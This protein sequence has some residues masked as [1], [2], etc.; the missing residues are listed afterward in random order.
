MRKYFLIFLT[1]SFSVVYSQTNSPSEIG[2]KIIDRVIG[3]TSFDLEVVQQQPVLDIQVLDFQKAGCTGGISYALCY[4]EAEKDTT[5]ELCISYSV[6]VK[7]FLNDKKIYEDKTGKKFHFKE[8]AYGIFEFN[9]TVSTV[10]KKGRN[11]ILVKS[12]VRNES[13]FI[14]L[15]ELTPAEGKACLSFTAEPTV[16]KLNGNPWLFIG[17]FKSKSLN[18]VFPPENKFELL[19][20]TGKNE[21]KWHTVADNLLLSA[22]ILPQAKF[23]KEAYSEWTYANGAMFFTILEF[24]KKISNQKYADFAK[25]FCNFTVTT[26]PLFKKQY[27]SDHAFRGFNHRIFRKQ[28][29][30]DAGAPVLPF[31]QLLL[32]GRGSEYKNIVDEMLGYIINEQTKLDDGTLCRIEPEAYTIWAD[33]LFMSVPLLLR[34]AEFTK[35]KKYYDFAANQVL[36]FNKYLFDPITGLY[37]HGYFIRTKKTSE[38]FWARANGWVAWANSEA[39]LHISKDHPAYEKIK[40]NF[41]RHINGLISFQDE[42]GMWHQ[43]LNDKTTFEETSSTAMFIV[44]LARGIKNGWIDKKYEPNLIR[45]WDALKKNI[46]GDGTVKNICRGTGIGNTIEFYAKRATFENDP[47]GMGAVITACG[48]MMD[49]INK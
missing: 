31:M 48:E 39:M 14:Y 12:C 30:D 25:R 29:L 9:D 47:R 8:T 43:V 2:S 26:M 35:E 3:D 4:A 36:N 34:Y 21:L 37:K 22:K 18:E 7:I 11:K 38:V 20:Q 5:V 45:A 23:K 40:N 44:V 32:D 17:P 46:S 28:M 13:D 15:R 41:I 10:F 19:C 27:Y 16:E 42:S 49:F 24:A 6:P 1:V 33:D